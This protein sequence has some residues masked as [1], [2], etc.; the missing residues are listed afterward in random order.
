MKLPYYTSYTRTSLWRDDNP[1]CSPVVVWSL[2]AAQW[3][4]LWIVPFPVNTAMSRVNINLPKVLKQSTSV[5]KLT[6]NQLSAHKPLYEIQKW[7]LSS[8]TSVFFPLKIKSARES[9][10]AAFFRVFSRIENWLSCTLFPTF[11]GQSKIFTD[12]LKEF[13]TDGFFFFTGMKS[14]I[15]EDFH[16]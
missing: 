3:K 1:S 2:I 12:T 9:H 14:I 5:P 4:L 7:P 8:H 6:T 16:G 13:F 15:F 10:F 11:H